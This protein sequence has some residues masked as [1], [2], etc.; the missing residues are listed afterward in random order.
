[1]VSNSSYLC[2][3]QSQ[4]IFI[5]LYFFPCQKEKGV[6]LVTNLHNFHSLKVIIVVKYQKLIYFK[7]GFTR[8]FILAKVMD[9]ILQCFL[10]NVQGS[11][12][13]LYTKS[14]ND[15]KNNFLLIV[16]NV[17]LMDLKSYFFYFS[18]L[19]TPTLLQLHHFGI[20]M[21]PTTF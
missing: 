14:P 21:T 7:F 10:E 5:F 17:E 15:T 11:T 19:I 9:E 12:I 3:Y 18:Q 1:M 13:L 20:Q 16:E 6:N 2:N 8:T 4:N